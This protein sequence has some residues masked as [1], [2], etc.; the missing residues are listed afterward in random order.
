MHSLTITSRLAALAIGAIFVA[1]QDDLPPARPQIPLAEKRFTWPDLPYQVDTEVLLRGTQS[2]YN[3][4]NS[5]T[6]NQESLCQTAH[7]NSIDDFCL[8]APPRAGEN[9][10]NIESHMVA[11]CTKPGHG[12]RLIPEG[13]IT[14]LQWIRT[15]DYVQAVG[16]FD[17]TM[18]NIGEEDYGG[19]IDP[20]GA[21][22]RGNPMGALLFSEA[23]TG[24]P[25]QV[26]N[27]HLFIGRDRFC[28]KACDPSR[29]ND[30]QFCNNILDR[31]GCDFNIPNVAQPDV[32][33]ECAADNQDFPGVYTQADGA[34]ITYTQPEGPIDTIEWRP[35]T[36]VPSDC[37]TYASAALFS[38]LPAGANPTPSASDEP[39]ITP[40]P[41][42]GLSTARPRATP[43]NSNASN[44][45]ARPQQTNTSGASR[46]ALPSAAALAVILS[47]I[48]F[49]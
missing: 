13:A 46:I 24:S 42:G 19:E 21:D 11:W 22:G 29:Q 2:G 26:I 6:E 28:F 31:I 33:E 44:G 34:V 10:G 40:A 38:G 15:P 41:S 47:A 18:V 7:F 8:W 14:G 48:I 39:E 37:T 36:P 49:A 30:R 4:C 43:S 27:W 23:W 9:I 1:A 35:R 32:F 16:F 17:E 5:T 45:G 12:T 3:I 25:V 20:H